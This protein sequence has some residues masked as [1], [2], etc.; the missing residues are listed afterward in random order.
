MTRSIS[1]SRPFVAAAMLAAVGALL[2]A[3]GGPTAR[4]ASAGA[5]PAGY[6]APE[7]R[8]LAQVGQS[9]CIR[10]K[11]PETFSEIGKLEAQWEAKRYAP[12]GIV[13]PAAARMGIGERA[14]LATA[15]VKS[16]VSGAGGTWTPYGK[17]PLITNDSRYGSV[18]TV[19]R[20][21]RSRSRSISAASV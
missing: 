9:L 19:R 18:Q 11:H 17:G 10:D 14:L 5:C 15:A 16:S 8:T 4:A 2:V 1:P 3:Q 12:L 13:D 7:E 21:L 6:R 20:R